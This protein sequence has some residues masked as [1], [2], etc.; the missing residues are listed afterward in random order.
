MEKDFSADKSEIIVFPDLYNET[1]NDN[2]VFVF[3]LKS[4]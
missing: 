2:N 4:V 3:C 1:I